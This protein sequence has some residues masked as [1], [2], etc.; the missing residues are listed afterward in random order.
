MGSSPNPVEIQ[1]FRRRSFVVLPR[2]VDP[3]QRAA[4]RQA[5][6]TV[7]EWSRAS[8]AETSHTTPRISLLTQATS[9]EGGA[10]LLE[11]VVAFAC[12]ARLCALLEAVRHAD[13]TTDA[14][15]LK[16][17]HYYHEQTKRDWDGDWHRD[18]Q[19][20][21]TDPEVER[22]LIAATCSV[23]VRLALEDD[24]RLE[25]VPA[26]HS[27]WDSPEELRL[28]RGSARAANQMPHAV[29]V[30]LQAGDACLFHAWS[31]HRAT[32][33]RAPIRRTLDLLYAS[34][35]PGKTSKTW[36]HASGNR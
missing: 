21:S 19:F 25:I 27:R 30:V 3:P 24:D 11:P 10:Q 1:A 29:R 26:S 18:S 14:L 13:R 36:D 17:A 9:F 16:E 5:C 4:L 23:H 33:R 12:S 6:D 32:Y 15:Q 8:C 22:K 28:R 2:F 34:T 7:L 20:S 35:P 31:I